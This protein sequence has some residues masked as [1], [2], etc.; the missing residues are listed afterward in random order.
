M[1]DLI[2]RSALLELIDERMDGAHIQS[3]T[4]RG[5]AKTLWSGIC[6][7]VNWCRNTV[8]E[9]PAVDAVPV[10]RCKDCKR[11]G[12]YEVSGNGCCKHINGLLC[13]EPYDFCNYGE[14]KTP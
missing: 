6:G 12:V 8:I 13:P 3:V 14:R 11:Y 10:V 5:I 9:A 7:G 1:S 2:S 4:R